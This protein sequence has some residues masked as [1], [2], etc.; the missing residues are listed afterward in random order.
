M[1]IYVILQNMADSTGDAQDTTILH[2]YLVILFSQNK[3]SA[4]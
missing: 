2:V 3:T 4:I 1:I